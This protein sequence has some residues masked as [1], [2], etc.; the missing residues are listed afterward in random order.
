MAANQEKKSEELISKVA[1][2]AVLSVKEVGSL[3]NGPTFKPAKSFEIY[4]GIVVVPQKDG[5]YQFDIYLNI[6]YGEKIPQT[7][8]SVQEAVKK[9]ED[10][11]AVTV[12]SININ[13]QGVDF[14]EE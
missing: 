10:E 6:K 9:A 13:I 12:S 7:A 11:I 2:A 5:S 14:K 1:A 8:F 4:K 3:V